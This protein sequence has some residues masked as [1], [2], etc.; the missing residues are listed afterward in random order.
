M[1]KVFHGRTSPFGWTGLLVAPIL[2][3]DGG[4]NSRDLE[5]RKLDFDMLEVNLKLIAFLLF[6]VFSRWGVSYAQFDFETSCE[7]MPQVQGYASMF[8]IYANEQREACAA[9]KKKPCEV[10]K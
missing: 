1:P 8:D 5:E 10:P 7:Q 3:Y 2:R 6:V 9:D 4:S